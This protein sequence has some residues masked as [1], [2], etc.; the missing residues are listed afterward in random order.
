[1]NDEFWQ[2]KKQKSKS[3]LVEQLEE[4]AHTGEP[5]SGFQ[6]RRSNLTGINLVNQGNKN[7]FQLINSDLYRANL[8]NAHLFHID[9][10]NTSLMKANFNGANLHCANLKGCNL[11]G[12]I[13]TNAKL[14]NII[15]DDIVVQEKLALESNDDEERM[16]YLQQ[17]EEIYRHLRKQTESQGL[18]EVAGDFFIREMSVRRYQMPMYSSKRLISKCV[19]LFCGYGEKPARV[20]NF[21][22]VMITMFALLYFIFGITDGHQIIE[23][24]LDQ[25]LKENANRF[26]E[27]LYFSVVTF[28]TLGYG[29]LAP[30]GIARAVAAAEAFI[31]SFTLAL[32]VVVFVKKMTR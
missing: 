19:D 21:S 26:L 13:F 29:D 25:N 14:D 8:C 2:D 3:D 18:F 12:T 24:G 1:M 32:F 27:T 9:L 23:F 6:L 17:A 15:W 20:I 5:M 28:T 30:S 10:H 22:M 4:R 16:D 11:L 31:G 7:G